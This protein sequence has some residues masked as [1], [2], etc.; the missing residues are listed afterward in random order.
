[1]GFSLNPI[2]FIKNEVMKYKNKAGTPVVIVGIE[3]VESGLNVI[4]KFVSR[5]NANDVQEILALLPTSVAAKF[6]PQELTAVSAAI[7]NLPGELIEA[8]SALKKLETELES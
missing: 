4:Q 8:E 2:T 6:T 1:M 5:L 7:A 3:K